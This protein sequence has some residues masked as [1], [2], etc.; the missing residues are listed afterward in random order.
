MQCVVFTCIFCEIFICH[1]LTNKRALLSE[2][3]LVV[4]SKPQKKHNLIRLQVN[5]AIP[6]QNV[7]TLSVSVYIP[8][9]CQLDNGF[10]TADSYSDMSARVHTTSHPSGDH[11]RICASFI[12]SS[13]CEY[14]E[15]SFMM[16]RKDCFAS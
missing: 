6:I 4:Q 16:F 11:S 10:M 8:P 7:S 5:S 9:A 14:K 3:T 15:R 13:L 2:I 12:L 1:I